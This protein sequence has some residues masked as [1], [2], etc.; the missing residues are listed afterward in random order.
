MS[1]MKR[2]AEDPSRKLDDVLRFEELISKISTRFVG[3][4]AGRVDEQIEDSLQLVGE[5][6][7]MD[8]IAVL[9]FSG[10]LKKLNLTHGYAADVEHRPP[11]FLVSDKLPWFSESLRQGETLRISSVDDLPEEA[12]AEREYVKGQGFKSFLTLP[13]KVGGSTIGAISYSDMKHERAWSTDLFRQLRTVTEV[14]ASALDRM[15]TERALV[16]SLRLEKLVSSLSAEFVNLAAADVERR[17]RSGLKQVVESTG[18]DRS[19]LWL[20]TDDNSVLSTAY[21]W[22]AEGVR[23]IGK[24]AITEGFPWVAATLSQGKTVAFAS[25]EDLPEEAVKDRE[26]LAKMELKSSVVVPISVEGSHD[27]CISVGCDRKERNWPDELVTQLRVVGEIL[28]NALL[29]KKSEEKVRNLVEQLKEENVYLR[30]ETVRSQESNGMLGDSPPFRGAL[31]Q[32]AQVASTDTTVLITGETGVGKE[33]LARAIHAQSGRSGRPMVTVNCSALPPTLVEAELFGREKGAYTGSMT[34]QKGRFEIADGST[35]FLDEVGDLP[36]EVQPKILRAIQEGVIERLGSPREIKVDVRLI[37]ATNRDLN[38]MVADGRLRQDLF[39]RLNV[40]PIHVPPLRERREDIPQLVW[41]FVRK[42]AG[43]MGKQIDH[44]SEEALK[45]LSLLPWPGNI[46]ELSNVVEHAV[47]TSSG[48]TLQVKASP[49]PRVPGDHDRKLE[50]LERRHIIEVLKECG[51]KISGPGGAAGIL[52]LKPT[53]L[54][55]RMEK[56]AIKRRMDDDIS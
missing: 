43:R 12:V 48:R 24:V 21:S 8:R 45:A 5:Y 34:K 3:L 6:L 52:G 4:P 39:Y 13:M 29:R 38:Q 35:L 46:R 42:Y 33:L 19:T 32:A 25:V 54:R 49:V 26:S 56:L 18:V 37:T 44:I 36:P 47:I 51:W 50:T 7:G 53:T 10:D 28:V 16:R 27:Y 20:F 30:E 17:I 2:R 40:F 22:A 23:S 9:Q 14:I 31:R 15:R 41:H 55:S 1:N 11:Q